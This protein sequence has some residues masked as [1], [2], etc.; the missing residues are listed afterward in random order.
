MHYGEQAQNVSSHPCSWPCLPGA[1]VLLACMVVNSDI[2]TGAKHAGPSVISTLDTRS[3]PPGHPCSPG[4]GHCY[5]RSPSWPLP[6]QQEARRHQ[7]RAKAVSAGPGSG[8][9]AR[10]HRKSERP[11]QGPPFA[12]CLPTKRSWTHLLRPRGM[13]L[14]IT[15]L[16]GLHKWACE[17]RSHLPCS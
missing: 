4:R 9:K 13:A 14:L 12:I 2:A 10:E 15:V 5:T 6:G 16:T 17:S 3:L 8:R 11:A 7:P 1:L